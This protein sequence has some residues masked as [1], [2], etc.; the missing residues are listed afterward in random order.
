MGP[1]IPRAHD[2][3]PIQ[4][5]DDVYPGWA[6]D[7]GPDGFT[8]PGI[9]LRPSV[10]SSIHAQGGGIPEINKWDTGD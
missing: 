5:H 1:G 4:A 2:V 10:T 9:G 6:L 3:Y 8:A 7:T